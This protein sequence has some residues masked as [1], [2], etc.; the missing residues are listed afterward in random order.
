VDREAADV[1][2]VAPALEEE[3]L[4]STLALMRPASNAAA[5]AAAARWTDLGDMAPD[6][7]AGSEWRAVSTWWFGEEEEEVGDEEAAGKL[8]TA[9]EPLRQSSAA[10]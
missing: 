6:D 9:S 1:G 2:V 5:A 3:H 10:S 8:R 7:A 4:S